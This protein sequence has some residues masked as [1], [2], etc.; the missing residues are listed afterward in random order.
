MTRTTLGVIALAVLFLLAL[1][2]MRVGWR[3]RAARSSALLAAIPQAPDAEGLGD[4][5]C[6]PVE[7]TYVV[8][9]T[10]GDWLERVVAH[11]LGVRS[12]AVVTVHD[13][14]VVIARTGATDVFIPATDL[15]AVG[16]APGMAG[17]VV[18]RDGLVV[19]GWTVG[20]QGLDTGLRTRHAADREVL[21][22]AVRGLLV[23]ASATTPSRTSDPTSEEHA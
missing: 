14:G 13:A 17:K 18:G 7:A 4:A 2:A 5:R 1:L 19:I 16:R 23:P 15:R 21:T 10:T 11:D 20:D 3:G 8:T 6:T 9:T 12:A 22:E